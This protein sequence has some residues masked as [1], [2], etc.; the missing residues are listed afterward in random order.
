MI[1]SRGILCLIAAA[2]LIC[3][4]LSVF[5]D[6]ADGINENLPAG[7]RYLIDSNLALKIGGA[8]NWSIWG[9]VDAGTNN[10]T[11]CV[12]FGGKALTNS[13][14]SANVAV[15]AQAMRN[16][17]E[18]GCV[19]IGQKALYANQ[20]NGC[21]AMG[22]EALSN[23]GINGDRCVA[24]G[25]FSMSGNTGLTGI[26]IGYQSLLN[27]TGH[28][29]IAIGEL[30]GSG[31]ASISSIMIG[32]NALATADRQ[33]VLGAAHLRGYIRDFYLGSG[34]A[35]S[36]PFDVALHAT[37]GSGTNIKGANLV[38]AGG[39]ST[40]TGVGGDIVFQTSPSG[41][42]GTTPNALVEMA[43]VTKDDFEVKVLEIKGG[44]D[45]S[46]K[47][48]VQSASVRQGAMVGLLLKSGAQQ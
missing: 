39:A 2:M 15:G 3:G 14:G 8:S 40:G 30:A 18:S 24:I 48:D 46:E 26:G 17:T 45:L 37:G 11:E 43:R 28:Y 20:G 29:P 32:Y 34:V 38:I 1:R 47:F 9:G 7:G 21:L 5:A 35:W 33:C 13:A 4:G 23:N 27:N 19:A 6:H 22:R 16:N 44:S 41:A 31:N 10:G 36:T 42:T 25:A 12:G